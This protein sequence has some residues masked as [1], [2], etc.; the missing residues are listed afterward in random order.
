MLAR[1]PRVWTPHRA[2]LR[3]SG[4]RNLFHRRGL[5]RPFA[6][7]KSKRPASPRGFAGPC[8]GVDL[9][10]LVFETRKSSALVIAVWRRVVAKLEWLGCKLLVLLDLRHRHVDVVSSAKCGARVRMAAFWIWHLLLLSMQRVLAKSRVVLHQLQTLGRVTT[11]LGGRV[12]VD[13][14]FRTHDSNWLSGFGFFGHGKILLS[15]QAG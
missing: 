14:I 15:A 11:I 10:G 13:V 8:Y 9:L 12:V 3:V 4:L 7:V 5:Q 1:S 6:D 2:V